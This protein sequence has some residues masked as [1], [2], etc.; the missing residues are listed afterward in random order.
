MTALLTEDRRNLFVWGNQSM[1][2]LSKLTISTLLIVLTSLLLEV[3]TLAQSPQIDQLIVQIWPEYDRPEA[4]VI[5]QGQL[6]DSVSLPTTLTFEVPSAA[7]DMHAVAIMSD[8]GKLVNAEYTLTSIDNDTARLTITVPNARF[9]FEYYD[10]NL[11]TKDGTT[12][13]VA[14]TGIAEQP[15]SQLQVEFQQP[16]ETTEITFTPVADSVMSGNDSAGFH[17]H[18][19]RFKDLEPGEYLSLSGTYTRNSDALTA[20]LQTEPVQP[21]SGQP[22][23]AATA[24]AE[25][26]GNNLPITIGYVLVLIGAGVLLIVAGIWI[27]NNYR[28]TPE[29]VPIEGRRQSAKKRGTPP[30]PKPVVPKKLSVASGATGA[31]FCPKCGERYKPESKFCHNCGTPR[32]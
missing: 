21:I 20:G 32:R 22:I 10:P 7:G 4:L 27:F 24:P 12:R 11:V 19:Y 9:Q 17:Y 8:E 15:V 29:P 16:P 28:T 14:F 30:P 31:K 13:T 26:T 23:T 2:Y 5:Y 25:T 1:K 18:I 6:A 3:L